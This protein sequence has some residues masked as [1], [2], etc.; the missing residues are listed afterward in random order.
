MQLMS[1]ETYKAKGKGHTLDIA[2]LSEGFSLQKRSGMARVVEGFHSFTHAFIHERY[3]PYLSLL[4]QPKVVLIY[5]PW[6]ME[7]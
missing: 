6:G 1:K 4:S 2:P 3:E 5:R 7:G